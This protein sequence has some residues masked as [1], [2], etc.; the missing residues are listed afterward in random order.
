MND[1]MV[2]DFLF[3]PEKFR[4]NARFQKESCVIVGRCAD[5]VLKDYDNVLR[6]FVHAPLEDCM[7]TVEALNICPKNQSKNYIQTIDKRRAAYYHYF[8]GKDWKDADNYDLCLNTSH[9]NWDQ[10]IELVKAYIQ[11]KFPDASI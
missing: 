5:F 1:W 3:V 6:I 8:T 9:L 10:C 4:M 2:P 11:I 7:K